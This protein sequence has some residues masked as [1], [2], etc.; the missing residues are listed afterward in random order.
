MRNKKILIVDDEQD[1][2]EFLSYNLKREGFENLYQLKDGIHTYMQKF[3]GKRFKGSLFVFD[4]RMVTPVVNTSGR[5]IIG[6]CI[7]CG[8]K[9]EEFYSMDS[10]RPSRKVICC[11]VCALEHKSILRKA[12]G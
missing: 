8:E 6:Q 12:Y 11:S 2:L 3:P 9:C 10:V 5:E 1:I 4:N 7:Y